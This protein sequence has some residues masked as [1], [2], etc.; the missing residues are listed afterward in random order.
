[1]WFYIFF[2]VMV[3]EIVILDKCEEDG[4][5]LLFELCVDLVWFFCWLVYFL[6]GF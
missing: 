4:W 1:M 3:R 5:F 2:F 6:D